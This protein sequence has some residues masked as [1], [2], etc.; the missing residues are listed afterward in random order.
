METRE[1][2]IVRIFKHHL[3]S[4]HKDLQSYWKENLGIESVADAKKIFK[5]AKLKVKNKVK[6]KFKHVDP[7]VDHD[8][9]DDVDGYEDG[10]KKEA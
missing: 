3:V 8:L 2:E 9:D 7:D 10:F 1:K 4:L 5:K 6:T